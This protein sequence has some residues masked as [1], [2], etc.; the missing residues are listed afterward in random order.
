MKAMSASEL[1]HKRYCQYI[2][3]VERV[4]GGKLPSPMSRSEF[5]LR[6]EKM[7]SEQRARFE[8]VLNEGLSATVADE[9]LGLIMQIHEAPMTPELE[10]RFAEY[11]RDRDAQTSE[12]QSR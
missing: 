9:C 7:D 4:L 11:D 8:R 5:K 1:L 6:V 2:Q 10:E 3:D 12:R